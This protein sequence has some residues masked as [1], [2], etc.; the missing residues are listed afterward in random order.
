MILNR[1]FQCEGSASILTV[2]KDKE[3]CELINANSIREARG[4]ELYEI[5]FYLKE[6]GLD[7]VNDIITLIFQ[8]LILYI[9]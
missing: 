8:V 5:V 9:F 2:L 4:I 3:W 1:F 6:K 7:H